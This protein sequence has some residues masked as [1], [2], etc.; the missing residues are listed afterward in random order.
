MT[1]PH[2][3]FLELLDKQADHD[4]SKD[5]ERV[6]VNGAAKR[7]R[8][9]RAQ[10]KKRSKQK[11]PTTGDLTQL[12][13]EG[14]VESNVGV[15]GLGG[16][17]VRITSQMFAADPTAPGLGTSYGFDLD[18]DERPDDA[19]ALY[20]YTLI[21]QT[22]GIPAAGVFSFSELIADSLLGAD[23]AHLDKSAARFQATVKKAV[24]A[25][26]YNVTL[27]VFSAGGGV[28]H[29]L[30]RAVD[31]AVRKGRSLTVPVIVQPSPRQPVPIRV[32]AAASVGR[33]IAG[34]RNPLTIV[35]DNARLES[36]GLRQRGRYRNQRVTEAL[37]ITGA[38]IDLAFHHGE[39]EGN[40][41]RA[42]LNLARGDRTTVATFGTASRP[43]YGDG[44]ASLLGAV[45]DAMQRPLAELE[46]HRQRI[47]VFAV[48]PERMDVEHARA[49]LESSLYNRRE[50]GYELMGAFI[51]RGTSYTCDVTTWMTG[52]PR[53]PYLERLFQELGPSE[54]EDEVRD[55]VA[56]G[57]DKLE[58]ALAHAD[59]RRVIG[60][61]DPDSYL[62]EAE[63][64]ML[65]GLQHHHQRWVA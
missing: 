64:D 65:A 41:D 49:V 6:P 2:R 1:E 21:T 51:G 7:A 37:R 46:A 14:N 43:S 61:R 33:F 57:H 45:H 42:L 34:D 32:S 9:Q 25:S 10:N 3:S 63:R 22:G 13:D 50:H 38:A 11:R 15:I 56:T 5:V 58:R 53:L 4:D 16:T 23:V 19:A 35:L 39:A 55:K 28:G 47:M 26:L 27:P 52:D 59:L 20:N 18:A 62:D 54:V 12:A 24:E 31:K 44:A 29:G 48:V 36:H 40:I 17:G 8:R 60:D 30:F